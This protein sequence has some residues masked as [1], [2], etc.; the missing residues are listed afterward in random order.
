MKLAYCPRRRLL[1]VLYA[2][3][4]ASAGGC[5][6]Q[7]VVGVS[8]GGPSWTV[9]ADDPIPGIHHGSAAVA[10]MKF[11]PPQGVT[12]VIWSDL[13]DATTRGATRPDRAEVDGSLTGP[14]G[15]RVEFHCETV[16]GV[17]ARVVVDGRR[18]DSARGSL[19]LMSTQ[20][21]A[22][23]IEQL[24][25]DVGD[26]PQRGPELR[27]YALARPPIAEFF[28]RAKPSSTSNP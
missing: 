20:S 28:R 23:Q 3:A 27:D 7:R 18:F 8:S 9:A 1:V 6:P 12:V 22:P 2:A 21:A 14:A 16:D 26:L 17:A 5:G 15:K 24:A 19:F 25:L 4:A 10:R 11:G 13:S